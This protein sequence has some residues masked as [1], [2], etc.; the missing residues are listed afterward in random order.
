MRAPVVVEADPDT[1]GTTDVLQAFKAMAMD[2][3]LLQRPDDTLH[4]AVLLGCV[5]H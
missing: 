5:E 1:N 3:L 4:Q 2:A